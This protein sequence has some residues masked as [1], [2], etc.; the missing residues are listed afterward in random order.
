M[1]FKKLIY[2]LLSMIKE[3]SQN[4]L[5]RF[6]EKIGE[7]IYLSQQAFSEARQKLKWE[8]WELF[9]ITVEVPYQGEIER[10]NGFRV[11]AIDGSKI[12]LPNDPSLRD[13]FGTAGAGNSSPCAQG[14]IL[15]DILNDLIVAWI[16]SMSTDERTL[17]R[18]HP[19]KLVE[20]ASF[21]EP[22][23]FFV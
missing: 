7:N 8:A 23:R 13:Y 1:P 16:E 21:G 22:V 12:N 18:E 17:A 14:S 3:S 4:A 15:Y 20:M 19:E 2:F 9:D 10:W 11:M 6:F 5:E